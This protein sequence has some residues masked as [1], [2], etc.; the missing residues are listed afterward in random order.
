MIPVRC[1]SSCLATGLPGV[2][3]TF[4]ARDED[5]LE[6]F[7]CDRHGPLDN[8]A[9]ALRVALTPIAEWFKMH[10]LFEEAS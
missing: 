8:A 5:G 3:A 4:V 2:T 1:C 9:I 7:E 10:D 6:W